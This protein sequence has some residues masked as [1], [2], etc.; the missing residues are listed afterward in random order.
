MNTN[1]IKKISKKSL[2][3]FKNCIKKIGKNS[4]KYYRTNILF[5]TFVITSLI[6]GLL[7]RAFTVKNIFSFSPILGDLTFILIVGS[8]GYLFKPKNQFKYFMS[9]SVIFTATCVINSMYYSNFVSFASFSFLKTSSQL[10]DVSD[11]VVQNVM[12]LKDFFYLYQ[13][14]VM[15]FINK[16]LKKK[17]YYKKVTKIE[18]GKLRFVNTCIV[19][20]IC[21][22]FFISTLESKDLSRL[23]KQWYRESIVMKF[24]AF[25]YQGNDLLATVQ[26]KLNPLFGYD[27][28]LKQFDE[29]YESRKEENLKTLKIYTL[30]KE[31]KVSDFT[32]TTI[33]TSINNL[34]LSNVKEKISPKNYTLTI[35][36]LNFT[37]S[38]FRRNH[39]RYFNK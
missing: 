22:G 37:Q 33:M 4:M 6:N 15:I 2:I 24:G 25:I 26:A 8:I 7:L 34:V 30:E 10:T 28:A 36:N 21:L 9:W 39:N 31:I 16:F 32:P 23:S 17:E 19:G 11:A 29:Y 35:T 12:E 18:V 27:N 3:K 5:F 20:I 13:I 14:L 38:C 1:E